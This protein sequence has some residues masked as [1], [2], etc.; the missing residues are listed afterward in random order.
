M[1]QTIGTIAGSAIAP[2]IGGPIGS[3][4]GLAAGLIVQGE[5]DKVTEKKERKE[6][7]QQLGGSADSTLAAASESPPQGQP[8]RVWVDE[9]AKDGRLIAGHF[10]ARSI[11]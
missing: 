10:D 2:G 1:G 4:V 11:P 5:V 3:L 9:T 6:L 8:V 7:S